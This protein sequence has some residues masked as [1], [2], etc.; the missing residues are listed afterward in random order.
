MNDRD[1]ITNIVSFLTPYQ[2]IWSNEVLQSYP[3]SLDFYPQLWITQLDQLSKSDLWKIDAKNDTS[4][5]EESELKE[6]FRLIREFN[7]QVPFYKKRQDN[8]PLY[9]DRDFFKVKRKKRHEIEEITPIVDQLMRERNYSE[10]ID[11]GGGQG[12][13]PRIISSF[14][15]LKSTTIDCNATFQKTG[16]RKLSKYPSYRQGKGIHYIHHYFGECREHDAKLITPKS[17]T[18]GL[19]T[20]GPLAIRHLEAFHLSEGESLVNFGCCYLRLDPKTDTNLSEFCQKNGIFIN[21]FAL[22]LATRSHAEM[23]RDEFELKYRVKQYRNMFHLLLGHKLNHWDFISVGDSPPR[24]Y[25]GSFFNYVEEKFKFLKMQNPLNENEVEDFFQQ[26]EFQKTA[27]KMFL[28]DIIRWRLGRPLEI[29]ILL[30][31]VQWLKERGYHVELFQIFNEEISPRN[32]AII[33]TRATN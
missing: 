3:Q 9:C 24:H 5:L 22:N 29:Y 7:A 18:I 4:M 10:V 12:H 25:W 19:H 13:L 32:M 23:S 33:A 26:E 2:Q 20:C 21:K 15:G 28:A 11:I 16:E 8:A 14:H 31:R 17:L 6:F 1:L 30:D 27:R